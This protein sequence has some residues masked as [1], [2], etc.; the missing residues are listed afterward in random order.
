MKIRA[1]LD[2][3]RPQLEWLE[4]R[5][6]HSVDVAAP[7]QPDVD[8]GCVQFRL[9]EEPLDLA[10]GTASA[11]ACVPAGAE[12]SQADPT[13]DPSTR[14]AVVGGGA[15][16]FIDTSLPDLTTLADGAR[17]AGLEV[18]WITAD[19]PG[20]VQ[21]AEAL[22]GRRDLDALHLLV[23][24]E[25]G[26]LWLGADRVALSAPDA[27]QDALWL[28]IG[29]VLSVDGDL[30]VYGCDF[31]ADDPG[32]SALAS[33]ARL[34]RA[35]VA[36][37]SDPT[38]HRT[39][40]GD[41]ILE[42]IAGSIEA[43][44]LDLPAWLGSLAAPAL[45]LDADDS[46]GVTDGHVQ[47]LWVRGSGPALIV[48]GDATI[49]DADS[50]ALTRMTVQMLHRPDPNSDVLSVDVGG[51]ALAAVFDATTGDLQVTGTAS[52]ATYQ[53]VLRT[54]RFDNTDPSA[55]TTTRVIEISVT[56]GT[57]TTARRSIVLA[58]STTETLV[59]TFDQTFDRLDNSSYGISAGVSRGMKIGPIGGGP[60]TGPETVRL[61]VVL[62]AGP[63]AIF[64]GGDTVTLSLRQTWNGPVLAS[65]SLPALALTSAEAWYEL[66]IG[67]AGAIDRASAYVL[68]VDSNATAGSIYL[69]MDPASVALGEA[70]YSP[71]GVEQTMPLGAY[72]WY[73]LEAG[74]NDAPVLNT[75]ASPTLG[76]V[77]EGATNPAGVSVAGLVV[78]GSITDP[79]GSA[80]EAIAITA[81]DTRLGSWQYSLNGGTGWL[82]IDATK[83]NSSTNELALLLG[84]T[85]S[86]RMLPF[87]DLNGTLN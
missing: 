71:A 78:D 8:A 65:A 75:A 69:G 35:D 24:G 34:T 27:A 62:S 77:L 66:D 61:G 18:V 28:R 80:V 5:V 16:A 39:V 81:L 48:D 84:P 12:R 49:S 53:Q 26:A 56:D 1:L 76:S 57:D 20:L 37:S 21:V 55:S 51:S 22:E 38:G 3:I 67:D 86:I 32:R 36:A 25:P 7:F 59:R 33:L 40:G 31:A 10:S 72:R 87:G 42:S 73:L 50:V 19:R 46:L 54:L 44:P 68:R 64:G 82:T 79:D 70:S 11:L 13:T 14:R 47:A 6:L 43:R 23:H 29:E 58:R 41:W 45:D 9:L 15:I 63:G 60:A 17:T 85:A 2:R 74:P 4:P 83:I 52:V 30:L